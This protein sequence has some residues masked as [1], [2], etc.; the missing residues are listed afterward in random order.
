[1]DTLDEVVKRITPLVKSYARDMKILLVEDQSANIDFYKVAFGKYFN[2]CDVAL[3]GQIALDMYNKD[4]NYYDL[5][6]TDVDMPI[7][8]GLE[9]VKNIRDRCMDQS[10]I[11]ITATTDIVK[12]QDLAYYFIDG[13][14]PKPVNNKKLFILLYRVLKKIAEKKELSH[15]IADLED[16]VTKEME[17]KNH[18]KFIIDKLE[19]ISENKEAQD[20]IA[21][22]NTLVGK[23]DVIIE[24]QKSK[25]LL[26]EKKVT[27]NEAHEKDLRFSTADYQLSAEKLL[28]Q[29]DDT[30]IDKIENFTEVLDM[31]VVE[32]DLIESCS[33]SESIVSLGRVS[34]YIDEFLK[35]IDSLVVFPIIHRAFMNL[36][37]FIHNIKE[38]DL[39]NSE[40]KMLLVSLLLNV[41]KDISNWIKTIFIDQTASNIYYFDA[42]FSNGAFE[43]ESMF[44]SV[45]VES[46]EV[47]D[48]DDLGFF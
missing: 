33:A 30:I 45:G 7:M 12:N 5:I 48:D 2:V 20:V 8:D 22:L 26:S 29:L 47:F 35:I 41:E 13:L 1:M 25:V 3:N 18:Y 11:V 23:T 27:L 36:N 21:M 39:Q 14:L 32:L 38:E 42:S 6:I 17:Y 40:K 9:L 28:E 15:Y 34:A 24:E 4:R 16:V 44:Y 37:E 46:D 43:I 31:F 10:I 19:A